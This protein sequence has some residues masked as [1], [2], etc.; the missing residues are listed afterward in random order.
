VFLFQI[1]AFHHHS[2]VVMKTV[3][4]DLITSIPCT[5]L[6]ALVP[7][8]RRRRRDECVLDR[9]WRQ[10]EIHL[11]GIWPEMLNLARARIGAGTVIAEKQFDAL[12]PLLFSMG[13]EKT[14]FLSSG[15]LASLHL[16]LHLCGA[17]ESFH[18]PEDFCRSMFCGCASS[19]EIMV[20]Q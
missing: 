14:S 4:L 1:L 15:S 3:D 13:K 5:L 7:L 12:A 16:H 2:V 10:K 17:R 11:L 18:V 9:R 6:R 20:S 8:L 19:G